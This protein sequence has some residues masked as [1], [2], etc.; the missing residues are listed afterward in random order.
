[1]AV[2]FFRMIMERIF[3]VF[4]PKIPIFLLALPFVVL[5]RLLRPI[6]C[7]RLI[8]VYEQIG[9]AL[10]NTEVYL[11]ER[12][13]GLDD[14]KTFDIFY[15][16]RPWILN[17]QVKRMLKRIVP[18]YDLVYWLAWA[19][20]EIPGWRPH[21]YIPPHNSLDVY[22]FSNDT[23]PQVSF[24]SKEEDRGAALLHDM[25]IPPGSSIVTFNVRDNAYQK[26]VM[27]DLQDGDYA[28]HNFRDADINTITPAVKELV[29]RGY[30]VI[31]MGKVVNKAFGWKHP[32][33]IDYP[34]SHW[35]S[36]FADLFLISRSHF[37]IGNSSG[38]DDV[39]R[40]FRKHRVTV[41]LVPLRFIAAWSPDYLYIFKKIWSIREKRFLTFREIVNSPVG[42]YL[43][44]IWYKKDG[45]EI[46]DNTPE[47]I[48]D[49]IL[50]KE[51]KLRGVW[52]T[53]DEYEDLQQRFWSL[54]KP[55]ELNKVFKT[56]IGSKFLYQNRDLLE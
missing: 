54:F 37:Y 53:N 19:N 48:L 26:S 27:P 6:M 22:G 21:Q 56:R 47:E 24:T 4:L 31:R 33:V 30:Y 45:L 41:N 36:D 12:R 20:L 5:I 35:R 55:D 29:Q 25:G 10:G 38:I 23:P 13:A 18:M 14:A 50:E 52:K 34:L 43:D 2:K 3:L 51:E 40:L 16:L 46:V 1:M 32:Q 39:A 9:H 42:C 17:G 8:P 15:P 44:P 7:I 11:W 49:V 28:L